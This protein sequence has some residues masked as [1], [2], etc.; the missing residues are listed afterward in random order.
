MKI[1]NV[2]RADLDAALEKVNEKF[3]GNV[4]YKRIERTGNNRYQVTLTV[5]DSRGPGGRLGFPDYRTGKQRRIAAACWHVY[6][7]FFDALP[8]WVSYCAPVVEGWNGN[9]E[10]VV[11][12]WRKP[13]DE[14][15]DRNIGSVFAPLYY[16][17]A[18]NCAENGLA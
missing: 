4:T 16:S 17:E 7:T 5:K 14:W 18:C 3:G 10:N 6:G 2:T 11:Y 13:G 15:V 1:K 8:E 12:R 9:R